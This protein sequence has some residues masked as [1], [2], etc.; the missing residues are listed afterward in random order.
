[1]SFSFS[2]HRGNGPAWVLAALCATAATPLPYRTARAQTAVQTVASS[3]G[4]TPLASATAT[5]AA[6]GTQAQQASSP[7]V[8]LP[9]LDISTTAAE[10]DSETSLSDMPLN[11]ASP[12]AS[13]QRMSRLSSPD[14]SSLFRNQPG[15]SSY[16]GGRLANLPVL[17]GMADDRVATV[18][19][20]MRIEPACPNH[21]N[22]ALSY[23]DPDSVQSATSVAGITPV[24]MGGDS[25]AGTIDVERADPRFARNNKLLVTGRV[26][27]TYR[28]NGGAYGASGALTVANDTFSLRY[29]G[30]Y[31]QSGNY[32]GGAGMGAVHSTSYVTYNHAVTAGLH[33]DNH[34]LV[35]TFGQQDTPREGFA[36]Q[37]MDMTN[38]RST[39]VNGKYTGSFN[40]GQLEA[41][42]SWQ[43]VTHAMNMLRDKGGHSPTKGMPMN[44]DSRQVSYALKATIPLGPKH[45]LK[46]GSSFDHE[47]LNDW[48]PPLMGSMMM[49]P[50]T[51]HNINNGHRDRLG[52]FAEW[53]AHWTPRVSTLLGFRND[54]VMMNTGDVAPYSWT[55]MMNM[56]DAAAARAFNAR[57]RG[58][59]DTNFD[60][61]AMTRWQA[62]DSFTLEGG[63]ARKSRAP[64]LYER[65]AWGTGSMSSSMIGW[66]GDGNGYVGNPN[67]KSEIANTASVTLDWHDP[68]PAGRWGL[69]VQPYYSYVHNYINV[70]QAGT[71]SNGRHL[72]QFANHNAQT[73]G[74][75]A[76]GHYTLWNTD[77]FGKGEFTG[78]LNWVRGQDEVTH[79]G[80]YHMMPLNGTVAVTEA[81]GP[82]K[83]RV[84]MNFVKAKDTVD[85]LR[86]EPRTPGYA[87]LNLGGSYN[88]KMLTLDA[89]VDNIFN[90]PYYL[91][92]GGLSLTDTRYI[93]YTR[94]LPGMGRSF[95][96][97]LTAT[98]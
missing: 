72:L 97:S 56:A 59:T 67:L 92:L 42:G 48:W 36:N 20:G 43:R 70:V 66:F 34:L 60:V 5:N 63:Y 24:S 6:A 7:V 3:I 32:R 65:Y 40:W 98:F 30:S 84:E 15:F 89:G 46:L 49:G 37:Y 35:V 80:L 41:R 96:V 28:S 95:N 26:R 86:A 8:T 87:L 54:L 44:N 90:Q 75:N 23:I 57:K 83:G 4:A 81:V 52:H 55:G 13:T 85:Y 45:T 16:G 25:I 29:N 51:Y 78:V 50:N 47:G 14:T 71:F 1:M 18:V 77:R 22:P 94:A 64:N 39:F 82:W 58:R 93:G 12:D 38:N 33:K 76:S 74:I 21:M 19:D 88:W 62:T 68:T 9:R 2:H 27:G 61:T 11:A 31:D 10:E 17:N 79:S 53:E 73:Y 69:K 91:P